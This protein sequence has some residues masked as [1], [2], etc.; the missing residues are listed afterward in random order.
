MTK[1]S[2]RLLLPLSIVLVLLF[3]LCFLYAKRQDLFYNLGVREYRNHNYDRALRYFDYA[4]RYNQDRAIVFFYRANTQYETG[5]LDQAINDCDNAIK[6]DSRFF[7]AYSLRG[8]LFYLQNKILDARDDLVYATNNS[9]TD[10]EAYSFLG[11]ISLDLRNYQQS[12]EYFDICEKYNLDDPSI[13]LFRAMARERIKD[14]EGSLT[15][16]DKASASFQGNG[17]LMAEMAADY[18]KLGQAEKAE[19]MFKKG[20]EESDNPGYVRCRKADI[21]ISEGE[22]AKALDEIDRALTAGYDGYLPYYLKGFIKGYLGEY[23]EAVEMLDY[24]ISINSY[25]K[26]IL[27]NNGYFNIMLHNYNIA[28]TNLHEAVQ[29]DPNYPYAYKN[30][31]ILFYAEGDYAR[32]L[33]YIEKA[34]TLKENYAEAV[35]YRGLVKI[36][37]GDNESGEDDIERARGLDSGIDSTIRFR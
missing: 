17:L 25:D 3:V 13:F 12:I 2:L 10:L 20:I 14:Y 31:G 11:K 33:E 19:E 34:L 37:I 1:I 9:F 28:L 5:D 16:L 32:A 29:L 18:W 23:A 22:Y 21:F 30:L 27:N 36:K 8:K 15:D 26:E 4:L 7:A 24:A 35:Y 6:E